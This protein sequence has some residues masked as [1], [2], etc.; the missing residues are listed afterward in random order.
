MA[1]ILDPNGYSIELLDEVRMVRGAQEDC[2]SQN[3]A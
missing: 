2:K 3:K 1:F